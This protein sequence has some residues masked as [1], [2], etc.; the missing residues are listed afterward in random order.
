MLTLQEN[1]SLKLHSTMRLGGTARYSCSIKSEEELLEAVDFALEHKLPIRVIGSGS[2][3]IWRDEGWPGL[4]ICMG[5]TGYETNN[6]SITFGAGMI[7][8]EAVKISLNAGLHGLDTLSYIPGTVGATPVQNVGA[9]GSEIKDTMVSLRAYDMHSRRFVDI[10]TNDCAF[11][12]RTSRFKTYDSGRFLITSVTFNLQ[13]EPLKPPF[14]SSLQTYLD[15]NNIKEYQADTIRNAVIDIRKSKLPD[16]SLHANNGSFF[17]NPLVSTVTYEELK[18]KY[19]NIVGWPSENNMVKLAAAWLIEEAGYKNFHDKNTGM[20]TW[21]TQCL[22]LV[23]EHATSTQ[24]LI[25]FAQQI[26]S[27][28]YDLFGVHLQQEPEILP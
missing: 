5:I 4:L 19:P 7:W 21:H 11:A 12:Y 3:I 18:E 22:V 15:Q 16:P 14:Y 23:N 10:E 20:S 9:Y 1:V 8:D 2:N 26:Q 25:A 24:Q 27:K 28:V 17:A 6:T 13:K